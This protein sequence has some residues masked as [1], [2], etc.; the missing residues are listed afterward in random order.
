MVSLGVGV[1]FDCCVRREDY[2]IFVVYGQK[3][4]HGVQLQPA[5]DI[6]VYD[7]PTYRHGTNSIDI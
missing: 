5:R 4:L 2:T 1:A 7:V 3:Q 6:Q